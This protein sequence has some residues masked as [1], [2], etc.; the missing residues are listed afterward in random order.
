MFVGVDI[1]DIERIKLASQRTPR[2]LYRVFTPREIE[3]CL[4]KKDPYP[5]L[6]VRFAAKEAFRKLHPAFSKGIAFHDVEVINT[7]SGSPQ[8][9]LH[10][11]ALELKKDLGMDDLAI[12]LSHAK[13]QAIATIV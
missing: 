5:S 9:S 12:S 2:F 6:A 1:V 8:L 11:K 7:T 4:R 10:N 3:Y 13:Y